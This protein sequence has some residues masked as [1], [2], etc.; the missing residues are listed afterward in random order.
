MCL[1]EECG[2]SN[3][4][5]Q[6]SRSSLMPGGSKESHRKAGL[7]SRHDSTNAGQGAPAE[8]LL[9]GHR[10]HFRQDENHGQAIDQAAQH[11]TPRALRQ[12]LGPRIRARGL[13]TFCSEVVWGPKLFPLGPQNRRRVRSSRHV[14]LE[15]KHS[16]DARGLVVL[17]I[18]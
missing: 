2:P 5:R 4:S 16:N 8:C 14:L 18:N 1:R 7:R 15:R 12:D 11:T 17:H 6:L 3:G 10:S 13:Q 9:R